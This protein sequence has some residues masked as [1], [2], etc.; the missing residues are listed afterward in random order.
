MA[1]RCEICGRSYS[2]GVSGALVSEFYDGAVSKRPCYRPDCPHTSE[3]AEP[4]API[5]YLNREESAAMDRALRNSV[6]V[7]SEGTPAD[8]EAAAPTVD[9]LP[10][11]K[12]FRAGIDTLP[13]GYSLPAHCDKE[14]LKAALA[15]SDMVLVKRDVVERSESRARMLGWVGNR[16]EETKHKADAAYLRGKLEGK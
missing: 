6:T 15:A 1:D 2:K 16:E 14:F 9:D 11:E 8:V 13:D 7:I 3:Q 10:W 12:M 5:R 4:D